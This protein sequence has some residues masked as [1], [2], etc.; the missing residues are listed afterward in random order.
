VTSR[1]R[2]GVIGPPASVTVDL[3]TVP[4]TTDVVLRRFV[5]NVAR[6]PG[7]GPTHSFRVRIRRAPPQRVSLRLTAPDGTTAEAVTQV[8]L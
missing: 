8:G 6:F 5:I 4:L 3:A 2:L 7:D 1:N